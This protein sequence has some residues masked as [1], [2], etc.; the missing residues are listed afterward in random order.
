MPVDAGADGGA[1][2]AIVPSDRAN[3]HLP[4][5][6]FQDEV[7]LWLEVWSADKPELRDLARRLADPDVDPWGYLVHLGELLLAAE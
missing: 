3:E 5:L 2:V 7:W 1:S 6:A 4:D